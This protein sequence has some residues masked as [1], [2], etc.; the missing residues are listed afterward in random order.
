M[1][2]SSSRY[3]RI[4]GGSM[5]TKVCSGGSGRGG[6][7]GQQAEDRFAD[8]ASQRYDVSDWAELA[9]FLSDTVK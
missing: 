2:G 4:V 6:G 5:R 1:A 9:T 7:G 8:R 3:G